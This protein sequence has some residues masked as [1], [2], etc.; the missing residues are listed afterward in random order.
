MTIENYLSKL[1]E[2]VDEFDPTLPNPYNFRAI[3]LDPKVTREDRLK[4]LEQVKKNKK[5]FYEADELIAGWKLV[6][7]WNNISY[8]IIDNGEKVGYISFEIIIPEELKTGKGFPVFVATWVPG[9]NYATRAIMKL[10]TIKPLSK[11]KNL[12]QLAFD[13]HDKNKAMLKVLRNLKATPMMVPV[14]N[15]SKDTGKVKHATLPGTKI[16]A[17]LVKK[18]FWWLQGG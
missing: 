13:V 1:Q 7:T 11:A 14:L 9:H 15:G 4:T 18:P 17:Y 3:T 6:P 8:S 2:G 5:Y 16:R 10:V 12:M